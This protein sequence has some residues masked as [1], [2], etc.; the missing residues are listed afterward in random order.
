M[1]SGDSWKEDPTTN[2]AEGDSWK[3]KRRGQAAE[4]WLQRTALE[5]R[6]LSPGLLEP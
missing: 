6:L 3:Q 1:L 5:D 2:I 4:E